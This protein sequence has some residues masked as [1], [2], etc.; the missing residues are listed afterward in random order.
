MISVKKK[1]EYPMELIHDNWYVWDKVIISEVINIKFIMRVY[2]T[3]R[4]KMK[5]YNFR[6]SLSNEVRKI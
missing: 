2:I 5:K 4:I 1:F 6:K 3:N